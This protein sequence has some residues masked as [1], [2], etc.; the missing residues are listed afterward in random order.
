M[1][2][3]L[4]AVL[5]ALAVEATGF[6]RPYETTIED[7]AKVAPY[8]PLLENV[9]PKEAVKRDLAKWLSDEENMNQAKSAWALDGSSKMERLQSE[10]PFQKAK[11]GPPKVEKISA[12]HGKVVILSADYVVEGNEDSFKEEMA[13]FQ[14]DDGKKVELLTRAGLA[15]SF[16]DG[17]TI[18]YDSPREVSLPQG[19]VLGLRER[20]WYCAEGDDSPRPDKIRWL[21]FSVKAGVQSLGTFKGKELPKE[22]CPSSDKKSFSACSH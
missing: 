1:T 7:K 17:W 15:V 5:T 21:L 6:Y 12:M 4:F 18:S 19:V 8:L 3:I 16:C 20:N 13:F 9:R 11:V 14:S 10:T 22:L 2:S